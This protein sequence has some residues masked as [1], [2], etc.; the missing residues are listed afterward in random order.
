MTKD[1]FIFELPCYVY[2]GDK[3]I[4]LNLNWYRNAHFQLL[5]KTKQNYFPL[6]FEKFHAEKISIEYLLIWN[7]NRR[8]D[9]MN[10]ISIADKYFMDWL[11][12]LGYI[13]DDC[14][15]KCPEIYA[16]CKI[17][18]SIKES[19]IQAKVIIL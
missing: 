5:N 14:L 3:K 11:V 4:S 6:K 17:D 19:Y 15:T 12:G 2:L 9:L 16:T 18:T 8:T 13:S 10:W 7:S 1:S